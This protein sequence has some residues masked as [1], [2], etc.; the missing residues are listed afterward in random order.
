MVSLDVDWIAF[1]SGVIF[2]NDESNWGQKL[3]SRRALGLSHLDRRSK[4]SNALMLSMKP[5]IPAMAYQ[6]PSA[7]CWAYVLKMGSEVISIPPLIPP[8][9]ISILIAMI[10]E[11]VVDIKINKVS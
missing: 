7:S 4:Y 11:P 5:T 6:Y 9:D 3:D 2:T 1:D 8:I 10:L